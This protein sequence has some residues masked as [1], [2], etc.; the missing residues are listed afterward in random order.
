MKNERNEKAEMKTTKMKAELK[1]TK[2]QNNPNNVK[3]FK[4]VPRN[5]LSENR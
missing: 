3:L 5:V 1:T 2:I 4:L